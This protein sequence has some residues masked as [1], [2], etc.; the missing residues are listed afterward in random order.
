MDALVVL[1][2]LLRVQWNFSFHKWKHAAAGS[3]RAALCSL[4]LH[5]LFVV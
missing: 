4:A 1:K 3:K 5:L 2:S